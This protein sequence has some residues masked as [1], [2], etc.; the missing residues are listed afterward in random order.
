MSEFLSNNKIIKNFNV[1]GIITTKTLI[2]LD[3]NPGHPGYCGFDYVCEN[4][5]ETHNIVCC[6][7]KW[8]YREF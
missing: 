2:K 6:P 7:Y 8:Y 4:C 5:N 1:M 3:F